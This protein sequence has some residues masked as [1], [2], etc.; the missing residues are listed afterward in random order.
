MQPSMNEARLKSY[1]FIRRE[2]D[3][4]MERLKELENDTLIPAIKQGESSQHA[5]GRSD[6]MVNAI[7][8]LMNYKD[9][10]ADDMERKMDEMDAI[11]GAVASLADPRE[12]EVLRLRY[13]D[14]KGYRHTGWRIVAQK[15][16]GDDDEAQ[17]QMVY[18]IHRKALLNIG[19][20]GAV[21]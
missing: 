18:R 14:C 12:R 19:K 2:V 8:R 1:I 13:I 6:R 15:M 11:K 20:V 10:I 7:I 21:K 5:G 17:L 4:Q 3:H 16:Y 9:E